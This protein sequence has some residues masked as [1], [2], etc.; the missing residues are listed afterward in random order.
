V[1]I[2]YFNLREISGQCLSFHA[3]CKAAMVHKNQVYIVQSSADIPQIL[4]ACDTE[5]KMIEL[6]RGTQWVETFSTP[7]DT[8]CV[9]DS[10]QLIASGTCLVTNNGRHVKIFER[11][12]DGKW[13]YKISPF[14]N[15]G[16]VLIC[17]EY[18]R[19]NSCN[20]FVTALCKLN[21]RSEWSTKYCGKNSDGKWIE[22]PVGVTNRVI[23]CDVTRDGRCALVSDGNNLLIYEPTDEGLEVN[24]L[25]D[26]GSRLAKFSPDGT[27]VVSDYGRNGAKIY[28]R[29]NQGDWLEEYIIHDEEDRHPL[30][31]IQYS[32]DGTA[33]A[34]IDRYRVEIFGRDEEGAWGRQAV[35]DDIVRGHFFSKI[36]FSPYGTHGVITL[37]SD[38]Y[39]KKK[40]QR[41]IGKINNSSWVRKAHVGS[42][43][44]VAFSPDDTHVAIFTGYADIGP[45]IT[46]CELSDERKLPKV[47]TIEH[48]KKVRSI[49]FSDDGSHIITGS[50][51]GLVRIWGQLGNSR[52][53]EKVVIKHHGWVQF[54]QFVMGMT[55]VLAC[56]NNEA[57]LYEL[58][59]KAKVFNKHGMSR[60]MPRDKL[61]KAHNPV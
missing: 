45:Q 57:N 27:R 26:R 44:L 37:A 21:G 30:K 14:E 50:D 58:K 40:R 39:P 54:A 36:I 60:R 59:P 2:M 19:P 25:S 11:S 35:F 7:Y 6:I 47:A 13:D 61:Q 18:A 5:I 23:A 3:K 55:H 17:T 1:E 48:G 31:N 15:S 34:L 51:D 29:S 28:I 16:N 12:P 33:I 4:S 38:I 32:P 49:Q 8:G 22:L 42:N 52:W 53:I 43:G 56:C 20:V 9:G 24:T 10:I 41:I 46:L